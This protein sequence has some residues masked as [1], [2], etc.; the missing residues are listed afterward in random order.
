LQQRDKEGKVGRGERDK[1]E[2]ED[3][4]GGRGGGERLREEKEGRRVVKRWK[5]ETLSQVYIL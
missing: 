1:Q 3:V 2:R 5:G 4:N